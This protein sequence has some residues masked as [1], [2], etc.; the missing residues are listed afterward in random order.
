LTDWLSITPAVGLS[1]PARG[2][3][4]VHQ[5]HMI[6]CHTPLSRHAS[7]FAAP[8]YMPVNPCAQTPL[9]ARLSHVENGIEDIPQVR[10]ARPP[11]ARWQRQVRSITAHSASTVSLA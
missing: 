9:A 2:L 1:F 3:A 8:S 6:V 11:V 4:Q 5:Q 10:L 7:N